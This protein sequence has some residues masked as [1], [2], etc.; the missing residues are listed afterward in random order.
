MTKIRTFY[1]KEVRQVISEGWN[2]ITCEKRQRYRIIQREGLGYK[3]QFNPATF[4]RVHVPSY[5]CKR[6]CIC[7][8]EVSIFPLSTVFRLDFGIVQTVWYSNVCFFVI[9]QTCGI[10]FFL[11]FFSFYDCYCYV[12]FK[13]PFKTLT[14]SQIHNLYLTL[15]S[16]FLL[17]ITLRHPYCHSSFQ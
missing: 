13:I 15:I 9:F 6:P 12:N 4:T 1:S 8:L 16:T 11:F 5:E 14:L 2:L 3:N 10:C 7:V 17:L